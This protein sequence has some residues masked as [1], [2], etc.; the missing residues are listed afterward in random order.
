VWSR[1]RPRLAAATRASQSCGECA[2]LL[3][4]QFC[5]G[6]FVFFLARV[7][8]CCPN[9]VGTLILTLDS[10]GECSVLLYSL[11]FCELLFLCDAGCDGKFLQTPV[12]QQR[13]RTA[14]MR[15]RLFAHGVAGFARASHTLHLPLR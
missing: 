2:E 9:N 10:C 4:Q 8:Y 11:L 12:C 13:T 5:F 1:Q 7:L 6:S 14:V 15:T 3:E